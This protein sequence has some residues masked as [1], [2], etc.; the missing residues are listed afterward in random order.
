M[1]VYQNTSIGPLLT[2]TKSKITLRDAN[3]YLLLTEKSMYLAAYR[4]L[5]RLRH[6][7]GSDRNLST[8]QNVIRRKFQKIDF[9][10]R[11]TQVLGIEQPLTNE[12]LAQRL[13]NTIAFVFNSTCNKTDDIPPVQYYED[14]KKASEPRIE[15]SVVLTILLMDHQAPN[16]IKYDF[17]YKWVG[18]V[19]AF[20]GHLHEGKLNRKE[21]NRLFNTG[22]ASH[23]GFLQYEESLMALN[24]CLS[25]CL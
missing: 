4:Q 15:T 16:E 19:K 8:Y 12:Q 25:L 10:K 2:L 11:R 7:V 22:R 5:F 20:Y 9:Q 21:L 18:D 24:E 17:S 14:V 13:A 6:L 23:L 3:Y 1:R